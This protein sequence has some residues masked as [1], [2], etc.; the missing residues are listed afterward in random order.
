MQSLTECPWI[1]NLAWAYDLIAESGALT[2]GDRT[3]IETDLL[4]ASGDQIM[5]RK[6]SANWQTWHNSA[7]ASVGWCIGNETLVRTA[8]E[9]PT[10][11]ALR[12]IESTF[13]PDGFQMEG[14][15]CYHYYALRALRWTLDGAWHKGLN[16]YGNPRVKQI[17]LGPP[18]MVMPNGE[19]PSVNDGA[20]PPLSHR[21][22]QYEVALARIDD[23][24]LASL[25]SAI[26]DSIGKHDPNSEP[27]HGGATYFEEEITGRHSIEAL[28][29]GRPLPERGEFA[30]AS[31]ILPNIGF[32]ALRTGGNWAFIDF[33][34]HGG[35]H[36][37]QD[38]LSVSFFALGRT[39]APGFGAIGYG[40]PSFRTWNRHTAA[41]NT[42]A[43][44]GVSQASAT[45]SIRDFVASPVVQVA[46]AS[47]DAAYEGTH[48]RRILWLTDE[49]MV[50]FFRVRS[51]SE[52]QVDWFW[53]SWGTPGTELPLSP[54]TEPAGT[55]SGY[56]HFTNQRSAVTDAAWRVDWMQDKGRV[57]M[58]MLGCPGTE[59][60]LTEG[61]GTI[62]AQKVPTAIVRRHARDTIYR[63]VVE[64]FEKESRIARIE[65]L[66]SERTS[67]VRIRMTDG[68]IRVHVI[69]DGLAKFG[70]IVLSRGVA[71]AS[72]DASG[73]LEWLQFSGGK[74]MIAGDARISMESEGSVWLCRD[75]K[76]WRLGVVSGSD[77]LRV[78]LP[79]SRTETELAVQPGTLSAL[80]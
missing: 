55:G 54:C 30:G 24:S 53:H 41:H 58:T 23:P 57:R 5:S 74:E 40:M 52:Q 64:P 2:P 26:Y 28:L 67:G 68:S 47:C 19:F 51:D 35:G 49:Y 8:I 50:D 27:V 46:D 34:P 80:E 44:N 14:S 75:G 18:M 16:L 17:F 45:G 56:Q 70:E 61:I 66:S 31:A 43:I 76:H 77:T 79:G 25:L 48:L 15:F 12:Q 60:I 39:I 59:I 33:G 36:G 37:H 22:P 65:D 10:R 72:F 6:S 20:N 13:Y 4:K 38:K 11:G 78:R 9:D 62:P 63:S 73:R 1:I 21:S 32:A 29:Y 71:S 69:A 42:V 7:M 3:R